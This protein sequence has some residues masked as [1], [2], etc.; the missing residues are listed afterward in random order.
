[1]AACL[2]KMHT[3]ILQ[4]TDNCYC[5]LEGKEVEVTLGGQGLGP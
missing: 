5:Y 3:K 4:R 1:V 2:L